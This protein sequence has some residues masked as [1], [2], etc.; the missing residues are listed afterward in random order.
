MYISVSIL[1]EKG[2]FENRVSLNCEA[3]ISHPVKRHDLEHNIV[4]NMLQDIFYVGINC[5]A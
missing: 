2:E 5:G 1:V 4:E 3:N